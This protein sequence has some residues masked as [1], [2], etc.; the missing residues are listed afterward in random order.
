MIIGGGDE[1]G[2]GAVIGPL[3]V[4]LVCVGKGK[5]KKLADIGVRDSKLLTR[6]KRE[7]LFDE[8]NG[9]CDEIKTYQI[10][11]DEINRAMKGGISLNQLEAMRFAQLVD[12]LESDV[13]KVYLD[14]PDVKP[15]R[16]GVRVSLSA[17]K[18][19]RVL[20]SRGSGSRGGISIIAEHKADARYPV[21]SSAS[22]IAKVTRDREMERIESM[23]G[24]E[25]G[26]GYPSDHYTIGAIKANLASRRLSPYIR[27]YWK[28]LER[29]KQRKMTEF[30]NM[31]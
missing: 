16:F 11:N 17:K 9:I 25:I 29:I 6:R 31:V 5:E 3:V 20:G 30:K 1:A 19:M 15:E 7:F 14:S 23:S 10:S 24:I 2:R 21:V 18:P 22:I 26:S 8:I 4:S 27:E 28:T 12:S 13:R